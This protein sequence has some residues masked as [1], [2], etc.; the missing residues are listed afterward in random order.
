[1]PWKAGPLFIFSGTTDHTAQYAKKI[2]DKEYAAQG[3]Q[4]DGYPAVTLVLLVF[5]SDADP[6]SAKIKDKCEKD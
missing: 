6:Y 3:H 5:Q 4:R 1:L 2:G